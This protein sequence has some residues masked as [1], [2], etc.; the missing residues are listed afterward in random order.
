MV[1]EAVAAA[2]AIAIAAAIA[3]AIA[4]AAGK[5]AEAVAAVLKR[6]PGTPVKSSRAPETTT[7]PRTSKNV[8]HKH[9]H[10]H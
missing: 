7:A 8:Y 1:A 10:K 6:E 5:T 9:R 3:I 4:A 2:V